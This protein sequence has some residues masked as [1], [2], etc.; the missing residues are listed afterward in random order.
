MC[1]VLE[2]TQSSSSLSTTPSVSFQARFL[3]TALPAFPNTLTFQ[4]VA[5]IGVTVTA[6]IFTVSALRHVWKM[7]S[8]RR[9]L[10]EIDTDDYPPGPTPR[11]LVGNMPELAGAYYRTLHQH[12]D[13]PLSVFWVLSTPF[14]IVNDSDGLRRVL[15]GDK[16]IYAKPRYFGYRSRTLATAVDIQKASDTTEHV[17]YDPHAD[18][19]RAALDAFVKSALPT[20]KPAMH[21]LLQ[22]LSQNNNDS[23]TEES[24]HVVRRAIVKLNLRVLFGIDADDRQAARISD[25]I[26]YAGEEFARRMVNPWRPFLRPWTTIRFIRDVVSLITLGSRLCKE[27]DNSMIEANKANGTNGAGIGWVHAWVGKV[28][29]VGKL[30]KVVGLL[31]ASTQTVPL[32]AVWVMHLV[33]KNDQVRAKLL[34]ELLQSGVHSLSDITI[35]MLEKLDF[36]DAV[37]KETLRLYPPFP[38]I[39]RQAQC[40]DVLC[41]VQILAGTIVYV[42]PWLVHRNPKLW[43]KPHE[44]SPQRFDSESGRRHGDS[45]NDW[46]YVPFGRGPRMCA[47]SKLAFAE[48]KVLLVDAVLSYKWYSSWV[49]QPSDERFPEL[50]MV[51]KGIVLNVA[52]KSGG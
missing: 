10:R 37:V 33:G 16:G 7:Y 3:S 48:L 27:L 42:V 8:L 50:G 1:Q 18:S 17:A 36:L 19:S 24:L 34:D 13:D 49:R 30:G 47:G 9:T 52:S 5:K 2:M 22:S 21:Q 51:P 23:V 6:G 44:F 40:D 38:L 15:G 11:P 46:A 29:P 12:V 20:I 35:E 32:T 31:M 39:Q 25:C 28:G 45:P 43:S 14:I 26:G 4:D 41:G